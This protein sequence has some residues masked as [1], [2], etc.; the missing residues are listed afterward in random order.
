MNHD[1]FEGQWSQLKGDLKVQ[2]GKFTDDDLMQIKGNY[3]KFIGS[4]QY[5]YG[6]QK[7][8]VLRWV[9]QWCERH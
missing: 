9:E 4:L 6:A 8:D 2:W 5:R 7:E 3:D 1:Q